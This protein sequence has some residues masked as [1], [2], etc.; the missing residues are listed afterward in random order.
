MRERSIQEGTYGPLCM[1]RHLTVHGQREKCDVQTCH[2]ALCIGTPNYL[3]DT[4]SKCTCTGHLTH[5][6]NSFQSFNV[7]SI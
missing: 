3:H 5:L 4:T 6:A 1:L 7:F 2:V